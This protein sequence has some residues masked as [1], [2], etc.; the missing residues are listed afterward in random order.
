MTS[1]TSMTS[2][3]FSEIRTSDMMFFEGLISVT[4]IGVET[5]AAATRMGIGRICC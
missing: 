3:M 2:A 5:A 1:M 4:N